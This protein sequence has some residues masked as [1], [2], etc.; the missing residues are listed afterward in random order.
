[1]L[2]FVTQTIPLPANVFTDSSSPIELGQ[3]VGL[4]QVLRPL[5]LP[6]LHLLRYSNPLRLCV[7]DKLSASLCFTN[8]IHS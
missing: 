2:D 4:E 6:I 1:M 5:Q 7:L 3:H 8:S